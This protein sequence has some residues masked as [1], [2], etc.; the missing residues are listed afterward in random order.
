MQSNPP[1]ESLILTLRQ[2]KVIIDV[3]LAGLYGVPTKALNQAVKRNLDRFPEDFCFPLTSTEWE[4][5]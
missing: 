3:D 1:L 2:Q 5:V 4:E